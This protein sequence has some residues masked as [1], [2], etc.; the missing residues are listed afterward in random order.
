MRIDGHANRGK[1]LE[2]LVALANDQYLARGIAKVRKLPTPYRIVRR[3]K[4]MQAIPAEKS[5][6]DYIG[7]VAGLAITFDC[8]ET[9]GVSLPLANLHQHQIDE[10]TEW[11]SNGGVAFW[12][13]DYTR[14]PGQVYRV[15]HAYMAERWRMAQIG[16]RKSIPQTDMAPEWEVRSQAGLVLDY[17]AGLYE[18]AKTA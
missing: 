13:V 16:G 17:L 4:A 11:E 9:A 5:G 2:E 3:G 14:L 12:L 1:V 10:A 18:E 8:K 7:V 15:P 6:L